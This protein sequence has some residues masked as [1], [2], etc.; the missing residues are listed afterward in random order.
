MSK[1]SIKDVELFC[2]YMGPNGTS[3]LYIVNKQ[4]NEVI[5]S[6]EEALFGATS[7]FGANSGVY[8]ET[9]GGYA[10]QIH[11]A[12]YLSYDEDGVMYTSN[13]LPYECECEECE[14]K[15]YEDSKCEWKDWDMI[16]YMDNVYDGEKLYWVEWYALDRLSA[17]TPVEP[18]GMGRILKFLGQYV[19]CNELIEAL[20][21]SEMQ[22]HYMLCDAMRT[23]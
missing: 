5:D 23:A 10:G 16:E 9:C 7:K 2:D 20:E 8:A 6:L 13:L 1:L 4:T 19:D 18:N 15:G 12:A 14:E 3:T 17:C 11:G 22:K 21:P